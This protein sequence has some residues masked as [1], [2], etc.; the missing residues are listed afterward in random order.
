MEMSGLSTHE[1]FLCRGLTVSALHPQ[2][3]Q[4]IL[5][6]TQVQVPESCMLFIDRLSK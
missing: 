5:D 1:R 4:A 2:G 3:S 6:P